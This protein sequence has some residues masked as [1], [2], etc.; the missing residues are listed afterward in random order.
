MNGERKVFKDTTA[1][2]T[3]DN[4]IIEK[5]G[6]KS[7]LPHRGTKLLLDQVLITAEEII[8]KF[9]VTKEVC[10]GHAVFNGELVLRGSD[11]L[12]M[13]AQLL[14]VWLAQSPD[15]EGKRTVIRGYKGA[16]FRKPIFPGEL[17]VLE[18]NTEDT[19]ARVLKERKIIIA[20]GKRFLA[21]VEDEIKAEIYSVEI[22]IG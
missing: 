6:I 19:L 15:F 22:F 7:I 1:F 17:L 21:K 18:M 20:I 9:R 12:D 8:G 14:G 5:E 10:E 13:A 16:K 2:L 3:E 4:R 11:L